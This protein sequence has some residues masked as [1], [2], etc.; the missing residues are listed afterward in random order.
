MLC[1]ILRKDGD[2]DIAMRH[3]TLLRTSLSRSW[4]GDQKVSTPLSSF[5]FDE[6]KM[7]KDVEVQ[8]VVLS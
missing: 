6:K 2:A 7:E 8:D 4:H 1:T 3:S 5:I